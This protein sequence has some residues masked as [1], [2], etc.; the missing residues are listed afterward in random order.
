MYEG[1]VMFVVSLNHKKAN[2]QFREKLSFD[3]EKKLVFLKKL[4]EIGFEEC[5]Y[6]STCNRCE[7]Y[8]V[9]KASRVIAILAEMAGVDI[10]ELKEQLLFFD[11]NGAVSHL[12]HVAAGFDSMVLGEDEILRQIKTAYKYS[13]D[14]GY[15]DYQ[16]NTIFQA[17]IKCAKKI[18]TRTRL[19]KT[20]VSIAS[21]AA[22]KIHHYKPGMKKVMIMGATGDTGNKVMLNLLSYG[23]CQ[24]YA[25]KHIHHISNP[26][27]MS[28]PYSDRYDYIKDMDVIVSATRGPHYTVIYGQ[29]K[30]LQLDDKERLFVDLAVPRDMDEDIVNIK[31]SKLI[32]IDDFTAIAK[33]N[34]KLKSK[35][36]ES[37]ESIIEDEMDSLIKELTF[38]DNREA[39]EDMKK[40]RKEDFEHFV[41]KFKDLAT[42]E[43]FESFINVLNK[44][45][46]VE[47]ETI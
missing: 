22:T 25:T 39:F 29:L 26:N 41:Y 16:L 19:S 37:G 46:E 20:S 14:N 40:T 32:T 3:E 4:K 28:I 23:D 38:H 7:V 47:N 5:I 2:A 27:A 30:N 34:N 33:E 36:K 1:N 13:K 44:M 11:G 21:L 12:F 31:G 45:Q 8:G 6:L 10:D 43:E 15:T 42:S 9:G 35:E 24:I 18:K 17:A